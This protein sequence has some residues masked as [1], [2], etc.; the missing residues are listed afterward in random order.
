MNHEKNGVE[1]VASEQLNEH[2][3]NRS[4]LLYNGKNIKKTHNSSW[5]TK[6]T[7]LRI[8]FLL[9]SGTRRD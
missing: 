8:D 6:N 5:I 1:F 3:H 7:L 2:N 9:S 4:W